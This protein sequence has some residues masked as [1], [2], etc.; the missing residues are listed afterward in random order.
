MSSR[1]NEVQENVPM[2][3]DGLRWAV[4]GYNRDNFSEEFISTHP[5][6]FYENEDQ[7]KGEYDIYLMNE[8][9]Y[10]TPSV[11]YRNGQ[12]IGFKSPLTF[13]GWTP[14]YAG[15]G[16]FRLKHLRMLMGTEDYSFF[17]IDFADVCSLLGNKNLTI[18]ASSFS[19]E[20]SVLTIVKWI[21]DVDKRHS[22]KNNNA[23]IVFE[24][25]DIAKANELV[26]E[27]SEW[28]G[29]EVGALALYS[30]EA[31]TDRINISFWWYE[32]IDEVR[33]LREHWDRYY[34]DKLCYASGEK[35]IDMDDYCE[36]V[37]R[38]WWYISHIDWD[39]DNSLKQESS[40]VEIG[41][42]FLLGLHE[43][44]RIV[45]RLTYYSLLTGKDNS[46]DYLFTVT[47]LLADELSRL[48]AGKKAGTP[49]YNFYGEYMGFSGC[50]MDVTLA[51]P[52]PSSSER[53]LY[54]IEDKNYQVLLEPAKRINEKKKD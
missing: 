40:S 11:E 45:E 5:M 21:R 50:S 30:D 47:A 24:G 52:H 41:R 4:V 25:N 2:E 29:V 15:E 32:A 10:Y 7:I 22:I 27:V 36:L 48:A 26:E 20:E 14:N 33:S 9:G 54:S 17:P 31:E 42:T 38:T 3:N 18:D 6:D 13:F 23:V 39:I 43:Y 35:V 37:R 51:A 19:A 44:L 53:V 12:H 1:E 34:D 8:H 16:D 28:F 49:Q 46:K